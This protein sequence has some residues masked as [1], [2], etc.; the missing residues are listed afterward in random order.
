MGVPPIRVRWVVLCREMLII[1]ALLV[2]NSEA[3][4]CFICKYLLQ[5]ERIFIID[6]LNK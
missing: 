5:V 1:D 4:E 2:I 3:H 6:N